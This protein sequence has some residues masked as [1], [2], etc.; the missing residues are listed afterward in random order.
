MNTH[1]R[2]AYEAML[3]AAW[4]LG[5]LYLKCADTAAIY[6]D[7]GRHDP[8]HDEHILLELVEGARD[9]WRPF[10]RSGSNGRLEPPSK[11]QSR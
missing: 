7:Q 10:W 5:L 3:G 8:Q 1:Q 4:R 6:P 2:I 9:A 11:F